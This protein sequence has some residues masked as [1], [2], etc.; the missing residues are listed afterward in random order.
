NAHFYKKAKGD[1]VFTCTQGLEIRTII[2][3]AIETKDSKTLT[4]ISEGMDE[5]GDIVSRF[6]FVWSFKVKQ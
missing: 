2:Q 4:L 1:I 5:A 3:E 6:E